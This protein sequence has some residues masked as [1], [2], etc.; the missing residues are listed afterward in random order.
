MII[1]KR[2]ICGISDFESQIFIFVLVQFIRNFYHLLRQINSYN[3]VAL[4]RKCK[5]Q[6]SCPSCN[7]QYSRTLSCIGKIHNFVSEP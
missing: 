5:C 4:F 6:P 2:E 1:L 3:I 7:I